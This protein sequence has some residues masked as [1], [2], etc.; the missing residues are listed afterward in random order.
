MKIRPGSLVWSGFKGL[1]YSAFG[2]FV[3]LVIGLIV[4]MNG[5]SDLHIWHLADL[6]EEFTV[7]SKVE[8]FDEYLALEDRLFRPPESPIL[9]GL[10]VGLLWALMPGLALSMASTVRV[11]LG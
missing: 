7:D 8:S 10:S 3:V 1:A 5:R 11:I 9:Y 6:D 4:Y 2:A